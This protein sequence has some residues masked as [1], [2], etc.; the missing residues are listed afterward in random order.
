MKNLHATFAHAW[1]N[2]DSITEVSVR[3]RKAG[4]FEFDPELVREYARALVDQEVELKTIQRGELPDFCEMAP[5]ETS[6]SRECAAAQ[7]LNLLAEIADYAD[8]P[9][10]PLRVYSFHHTAHAHPAG[11]VS[12]CVE[13]L[14]FQL[15]LPGT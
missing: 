6:D 11:P 14:L 9:Q 12:D 8:R 7:L 15:K 5:P 1:E 10:Q 2:S 4:Y 13:K 3:M